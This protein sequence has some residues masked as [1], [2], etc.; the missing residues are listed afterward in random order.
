[1]IKIILFILAAIFFALAALRV[2]GRI[3]WVPAGFCC[4]VIGL[5][6]I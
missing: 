4:L 2:P 5:L 3:D 6:L 1:M